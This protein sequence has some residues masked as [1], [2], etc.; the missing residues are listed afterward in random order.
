MAEVN[1]L[2]PAIWSKLPESTRASAVAQ[3][4]GAIVSSALKSGLGDTLLKMRQDG[5][6]LAS[7][8]LLIAHRDDAVVPQ[9][10]RDA[11]SQGQMFWVGLIDLMSPLDVWNYPG[12][13]ALREKLDLARRTKPQDDLW[14]VYCND[15]MAFLSSASLDRYLAE[16]TE[17]QTAP[18][19]PAPESPAP[20]AS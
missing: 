7:L 3:M 18:T 14:S 11:M 17:T 10:R 16:V 20:A 12:A 13:T 8:V 19:D 2:D 5:E 15:G 6:D 1:V 4:Q 9:E